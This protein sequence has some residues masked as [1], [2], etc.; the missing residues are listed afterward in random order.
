MDAGLACPLI[1]KGDGGTLRRSAY[2]LSSGEVIGTYHQVHLREG[3]GGEW[4]AGHEL[5]VLH[6]PYGRIGV[7]LDEDG[8]LPE[9]TR[10][11]MLKGAELVLWPSASSPYPLRTIARTRADE[12]KVFIALAT[13]LEENAAPA[14]AIVNPMGAVMAAAFPDIEQAIAG[15][16]AWGLT[17]YKEMAP[18][19]NVILN[20]QPAA[21]KGL[22]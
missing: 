14:T 6:T 22:I 10:V 9:V 20:R 12:N 15:Q 7:M 17:R 5:P 13:P 16:I 8:L 3:E 11:L 19:T 2:L 1:S 4:A 21:Y 18:N